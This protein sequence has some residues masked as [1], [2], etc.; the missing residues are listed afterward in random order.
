VPRP[1]ARVTVAG[2]PDQLAQIRDLTDGRGVDAVF[3][4]VG[5]GPTIALAMGA[6]ARRGRATIVGI[7]GGSYSWSFFGNPYE[8]ELTNTYWG[9]IEELH[10]VA[11]MYRLGQ[12]RP[13]VERYTLANGLEAYRRLQAG[14]I[15]GRAVVVPHGG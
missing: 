10:E 4:M 1:T 13:L 7:A 5:A 8:A 2:G 6:V 14:E 11:A 3:D 9:T 15:E 12:I